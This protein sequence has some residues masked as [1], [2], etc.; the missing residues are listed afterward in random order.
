MSDQEKR[1][2]YHD[3]SEQVIACAYKVFHVLGAGFL[4]KVYENA[5][6]VELRKRGLT[7][8]Q[9]HPINVYYEDILVGEYCADL[10]IENKIVVELKAISTLT[11]AHEVQLVNYLKA[12]GM[13]VGLL[14]NFGD[15]ISFKRKVMQSQSQR[16]K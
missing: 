15:D 13:Q 7:V 8:V 2:L 3:I 9:Q 6:A 1:L 10:I 16:K 5:L 4:E 12:T 14:I 11:K